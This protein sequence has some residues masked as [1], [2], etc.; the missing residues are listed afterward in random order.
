MTREELAAKIRALA[1]VATT[2][3]EPDRSLKLGDIDQLEIEL[4]AMA[5]EE[6][7]ARLERVQLP[8]VEQ[9]DAKI[10]AARDA[11]KS[12]LFRVDAFNAALGL[13][14]TAAGILL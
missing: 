7:R 12:H 2:L 8:D 9:I 4:A 3:E 5:L 6:T 11:T 14:K 10:A 13:L 1:E